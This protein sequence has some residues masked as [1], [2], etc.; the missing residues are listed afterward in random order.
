V[1]SS[2]KRFIPGIESTGLSHFVFCKVMITY[3]LRFSNGTNALKVDINLLIVNDSIEGKSMCVSYMKL[4]IASSTHFL[5]SCR[6]S[7]RTVTK[8]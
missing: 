8:L 2:R 7:M 5:R 1:V 4:E 6:L 3:L